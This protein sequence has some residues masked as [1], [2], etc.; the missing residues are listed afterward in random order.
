MYQETKP[1]KLRKKVKPSAMI[2]P[3][4]RSKKKKRPSPKLD[5]KDNSPAH[6]IQEQVEIEGNLSSIK[7]HI[8]T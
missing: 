6:V 5:V 3:Q 8:I 4:K 7:S 1:K 2:R